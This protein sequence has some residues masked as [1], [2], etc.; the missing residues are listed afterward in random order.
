MGALFTANSNNAA[1][2]N[3]E[4]TFGGAGNAPALNNRRLLK[5]LKILTEDANV[6]SYFHYESSGQDERSNRFCIYGRILPRSEP[7]NRGSY[8]VRIV[9]SSAFPF[10]LPE[11]E[12]LTYIY[13]PAINKNNSKLTF[14]S[15]C[16]TFQWEAAFRIRD[17]IKQYV[18]MIDRRD[19]VYTACTY[20]Y[21]ARE[22]YNRN[23]VAY[24]NKVLAMVQ[25][26]SIP[27]QN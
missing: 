7:Y 1:N 23:Y 16:C 2:L 9:L 22:L 11:L 4:H 14:C 26:Y 18:D 6:R 13:H 3:N 8:R 10:A 27:R 20:N 5:E 19:I 24:E 12:L 25:E 15:A 17:F 21:E